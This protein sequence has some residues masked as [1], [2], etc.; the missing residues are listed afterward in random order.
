MT[1]SWQIMVSLTS[2]KLCKRYLKVCFLVMNTTTKIH[3]EK[4]FYFSLQLSA[5]IPELSELGLELK[6]GLWRH[7]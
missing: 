5:H 6:A 7:A 4:K 3:W 2:L 1:E